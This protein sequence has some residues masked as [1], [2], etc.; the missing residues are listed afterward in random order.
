M[1]RVYL[2]STF[3]D[4]QRHRQAAYR[5][6][7][8]LGHDVIAMEDYVATDERPKDKC[9]ADVASADVYV[10]ILAW[11]YGFI[12]QNED[13]SITELEM[14]QAEA[15]GKPRL[16]FLLEE[17][18]RWP[19]DRW[20]ADITRIRALRDRVKNDHTVSYFGSA[21]QLAELVATAVTNELQRSSAA[22]VLL[23]V[24]VAASD[25]ALHPRE[26]VAR[27][28][29]R[30]DT[31]IS[32]EPDF[33]YL[34]KIERGAPVDGLG[35]GSAT[36]FPVV[37][38]QLSVRVVNNSPGAILL[39]RLVCLVE[40]S[41]P[42][43]RPFCVPANYLRPGRQVLILNEGSGGVGRSTLWYRAVPFSG[44][45]HCSF[46]ELPF[47]VSTEGFTRSWFADLTEGL[48]AQGVDIDALENLRSASTLIGGPKTSM[49]G[50]HE[51]TR[52][53]GWLSSEEHRVRI[54][55]ACGPFEMPEAR[56]FARFEQES[57]PCR[58][59]VTRFE[60]TIGLLTGGGYH[61]IVKPPAPPDVMLEV[62][63]RG[64]EASMLLDQV[65]KAGE[66]GELK[67]RVGAPN[68]STHRLVL[69]LTYNHDRQASSRP[70]SLR[71]FVPRSSYE[72]EPW[73]W[74]YKP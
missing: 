52:G 23:D 54:R 8:R 40:Q 1:A 34:A 41:A 12:P 29:R 7:R 27:Y 15:L 64:Y 24:R 14:R 59:L 32:I 51:L 30:G 53:W 48:A 38:P 36:V 3:R 58:G 70:F 61:P 67:L 18:A 11:R 46:D 31:D 5:A 55:E 21:A 6:L 47:S 28:T 69:Q 72:G 44:E 13:V 43:E 16:I 42:D 65:V 57:G 19:R 35:S 37:Y 50:V 33:D 10:G 74:M 49:P 68:P 9:L 4:L 62:D 25:E 73:T 71:V 63:G 26:L 45:S 56:L 17:R 2:S 39:N 60:T 66:S 22:S 20:D